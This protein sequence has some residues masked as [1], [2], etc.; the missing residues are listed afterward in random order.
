MNILKLIKYQEDSI[1]YKTW[2]KSKEKECGMLF[3]F[4]YA[5]FKESKQNHKLYKCK[6]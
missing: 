6:A 4:F 5:K 2:L 3:V 1:I